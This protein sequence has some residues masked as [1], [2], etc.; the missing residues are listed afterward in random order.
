MSNRFVHLFLSIFTIDDNDNGRRLLHQQPITAIYNDLI[1]NS[2]SIRFTTLNIFLVCNNPLMFTLWKW[3]FF[4]LFGSVAF[5][6]SV[7][8]SPRFSH[9]WSPYIYIFTV[10]CITRNRKSS[11]RAQF[12]GFN[13]CTRI[14]VAKCPINYQ[15]SR[16]SHVLNQLFG[17]VFEDLL[18]CL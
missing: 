9:S 14:Y 13:P 16:E 15:N 8:F 7:L 11:S 6:P 18:F 2:N 12:L 17:W 1:V 4:W 5:V 3:F 10:H